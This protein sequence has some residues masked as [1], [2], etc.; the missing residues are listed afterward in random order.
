MSNSGISRGHR[1]VRLLGQVHRPEVARRRPLGCHADRITR[2]PDTRSATRSACAPTISTSRSGLSSR[3][4]R[5]S[6]LYNTYS[7]SDSI[8]RRSTTPTR[9]TTTKILFRAAQE[10]GV[11]RVVHVSITNPSED[12]DL[13]YFRGKATLEARA[14]SSRAVSHAILRPAVLFGKEDILIKQHR[15][16]GP[17]VARAGP[18]R[19]RRL[20][21][22]AGPCRRSGEG[23]PSS[24]ASKRDNRVID[25]V[26][27][28]TFTYRG[29]RRDD[30]AILLGKRR[31]ILPV[32]PSIGYS[33]GE[34][35]GEGSSATSSSRREEIRGLMGDL[36]H[37]D[38]PAGRRHE[39]DRL[40]HRRNADQ[41]GRRY[42]SELARRVDRSSD[43]LSAKGAADQ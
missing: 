32:P 43:L 36:L 4:P 3:W 40:D 9:S 21:P 41:L 14:E 13:E 2:S 7:G 11:E 26:G 5:V 12:S 35:A 30:R 18:V 15:L 31:L 42:A 17:P 39:A 19:T 8:T 37:V 22:A 38:S 27:P 10:A 20:S 24:K 6:V 29:T 25:C 23:G 16:D 1:G 34:P 33:C 28:E